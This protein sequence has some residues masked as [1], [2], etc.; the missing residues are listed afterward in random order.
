MFLFGSKS[1]QRKF[2]ALAMGLLVL[3]VSALALAAGRIEWASKKIKPRSDGNSWNIELKVFLPRA[4]DVPSVP[5]KFVFLQTVYYERSMVDGDKLLVRNVPMEGKL[6]IVESV[7]IGFLDPR[8]GKI[9]NRTQFSFK[10]NR[11]H[12][13]ECGEY[14]V[15]VRDARNDSVIGQ[16]AT[17][18]LDG[19]NEVIDRR[20][21]VF[22]GESK[23]KKKVDSDSGA[24]DEK[25]ADE[26]KGEK[27]AEE[28]DSEKSEPAAAEKEPA[29]PA[30]D[31]GDAVD[32][33]QVKKKPGGCGCRMPGNQTNS[34]VG[35]GWLGLATALLLG[36]RVRRRTRG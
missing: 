11:D 7:D 14:K 34:V 16:P 29:A 22:S 13:F 15:T 8:A 6:P 33:E 5:T 9:E 1:R 17:L 12:G 20:S 35:L 4:P 28:A 36:R 21:L 10:I 23:K 19:E 31:S 30:E 3:L 24:S 18:I 26:K 25:K 32:A 2:M 27:K